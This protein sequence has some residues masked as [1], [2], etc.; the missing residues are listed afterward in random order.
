MHRAVRRVQ[1]AVQDAALFVGV[2][3]DVVV[4]L[5]GDR[6]SAQQ[7]VAVVA[8]V[9]DRIHAVGG[10][11]VARLAGE[12]LV[13]G[14]GGPVFVAEVFGA[15]LGGVQI[16]LA[17]HLLQKNHIGVEQS[18]RLLERQHPRLAADGGYALVDVVGRDSDFHA[19]IL[20]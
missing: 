16:V 8:V 14:G 4:G 11:G 10:V 12:I 18:D 19:T 17:L 20:T 13:L 9:V 15:V 5:V 2:V 7:R 6:E 1:H 3:G